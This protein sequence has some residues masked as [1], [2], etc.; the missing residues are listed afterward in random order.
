MKTS[1]GSEVY[2]YNRLLCY[3]TIK[4]YIKDYYITPN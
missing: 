3:L 4:G 1:V 2:S